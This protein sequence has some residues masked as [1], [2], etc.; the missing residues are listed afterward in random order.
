MHFSKQTQVNRNH[1][2]VQKIVL[3]NCCSTSK[4]N[5]TKGGPTERGHLQQIVASVEKTTQKRVLYQNPT[6]SL[7][8]MHLFAPEIPKTK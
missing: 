2:F 7:E 6:T 4:Q 8:T 3:Q 5:S 1:E